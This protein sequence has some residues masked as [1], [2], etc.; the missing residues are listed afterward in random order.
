[1]PEHILL[2]SNGSDTVYVLS[3]VGSYCKAALACTINS[4]P[5]S[6]RTNACAS[7]DEQCLHHTITVLQ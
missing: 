4:G 6:K 7:A 3:D 1:M 5:M 2:L